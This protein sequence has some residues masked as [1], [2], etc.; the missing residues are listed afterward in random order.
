M[1]TLVLEAEIFSCFPNGIHGTNGEVLRS[2]KSLPDRYGAFAI[3]YHAVSKSPPYVYADD[4]I[5]NR[6]LLPP[7]NENNQALFGLRSASALNV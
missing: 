5:H 4:V 3:N 6:K 2:R 7:R 1:D